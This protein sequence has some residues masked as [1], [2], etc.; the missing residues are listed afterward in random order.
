MTSAFSLT[1]QFS[2]VF[3]R[4]RSWNW[5]GVCSLCFR[6]SLCSPCTFSVRDAYLDRHLR[7]GYGLN[8]SMFQLA[9]SA[10]KMSNSNESNLGCFHR[11][12]ALH[13]LLQ[14]ESP[15]SSYLRGDKFVRP[16][17]LVSKVI[18]CLWLSGGCT[19]L[20]QCVYLSHCSLTT[21]VIQ[22]GG[23]RPCVAYTS[24][25]NHWGS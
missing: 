9:L 12:A 24:D 1:H 23:L 17:E 19:R 2:T 11:S 8:T 14:Y 13:C 7:L 25:C 22:Y 6:S 18:S 10:W 4:N 5:A 15:V 20:V 3:V 21:W 16:S